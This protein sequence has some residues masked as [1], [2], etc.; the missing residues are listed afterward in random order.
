MDGQKRGRSRSEATK[1]LAASLLFAV[2]FGCG[3]SGPDPKR[4]AHHLGRAQEAM[5][6]GP[7][8]L[9]TADIELRG[10][11]ASNSSDAQANFLLGEVRLHQEDF[12]GA[13]FYFEEALFLE[14]EHPEA[15]AALGFTLR[16]QD[17]ERAQQ[18]VDRAIRLAPK[19]PH[20]HVAQAEVALEAGRLEDALAAAEQSVL[21]DPEL[22]AAQDVLGRTHESLYRQDFLL[23]KQPD[24]TRLQAA[25]TAFE[26]SA[27]LPS[28]G[29][30]WS[31]RIASTRV[32][33]IWPNRQE[34]AL[35]AHRELLRDA[36]SEASIA[37]QIRIT[38]AARN[39]AVAMGDIP[40][41]TKTLERLIE[42]NP[43]ELSYWDELAQIRENENPGKG[44][45]TIRKLLAEK[46]EDPEAHLRYASFLRATAGSSTAVDYLNEQAEQE[47]LRPEML[48]ALIE[49]HEQLKQ[50]QSAITGW[51]NSK[52]SFPFTRSLFRLAATRR[53]RLE[54]LQMLSVRCANWRPMRTVTEPNI[55]SPTRSSRRKTTQKACRRSRGLERSTP[56]KNTCCDA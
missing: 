20:G 45:E 14:P 34:E 53:S 24:S 8:G 47:R 56:D 3:E 41:A 2:G 5:S 35:E 27:N 1:L 28:L 16:G 12:P 36:Q 54:T 32:L 22:A 6:R 48:G 51:P 4:F 7:S 40:F 38:Q 9:K 17:P 19:N 55:C 39:F 10:A 11:I 25:S 33:S 30:P 13:R 18:L 42:L 49:I 44:G 52:L 46:P 23:G 15:T 21:L 37:T 26:H 50:I 43:M 31:G 29:D